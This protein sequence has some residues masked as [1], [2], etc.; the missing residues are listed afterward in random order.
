MLFSIVIPTYNRSNQV[1]KLL[2]SILLQEYKSF[3]II[4]VDD[5]STD[6]TEENIKTCFAGNSQIKYF[7]QD[8]RERAAARNYGANLARGQYVNFFDSDDFM[9]PNHIA[10]AFSLIEE[11]DSPEIIAF[12][13]ECKMPNG[14]I[15]YTKHYPS[16][17]NSLLI[18]GNHL[19]CNSVFL[20]KDIAL[21][22]PFN[23]D[24]KLSVFEDWELWLRLASRFKFNVSSEIT[25][26][27]I[28]HEGR[29]VLSVNKEHLI[30]R[31]R[32]LY[33]YL[34]EDL[35]FREKYSA[36]MHKLRASIFSYISL[37]LSL[38]KRNRQSALV[39]LLKAISSDITFVFKRRFLAIIKHWL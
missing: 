36:S 31:G 26:V 13:Y 37:H 12:A 2:D 5:G 27:I 34:N 39:Y 23:A 30:N 19:S 17:L 11:L 6:N 1:V 22:F 16:N 8:N 9:Y 32:L 38:S 3:E 24:R 10:A 25:S 4:V 35:A 21:Q 29:S 28:N 20:R 33:M 15:I 7:K 14:E 18:Q